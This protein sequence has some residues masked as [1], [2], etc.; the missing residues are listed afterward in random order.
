MEYPFAGLG[1]RGPKKGKKGKR[2]PEPLNKSVPFSLLFTNVH[3]YPSIRVDVIRGK[4]KP[5]MPR[6]NEAPF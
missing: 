3:T 6:A 5:V 1:K 4:F 2:G